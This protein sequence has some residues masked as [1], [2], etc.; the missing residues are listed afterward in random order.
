MILA[1]R[2]LECLTSCKT[3][4]E[5]EGRELRLAAWN[6]RFDEDVG[7]YEVEAVGLTETLRGFEVATEIY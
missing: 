4:S 1:E 6:G 5:I 3:G 7:V 2:A